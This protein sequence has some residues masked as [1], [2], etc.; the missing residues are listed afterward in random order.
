MM[1]RGCLEDNQLAI[2]LFLIEELATLTRSVL[3]LG[4]W[5]TQDIPNSNRRPDK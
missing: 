2:G 4:C 1:I 3:G 5:M